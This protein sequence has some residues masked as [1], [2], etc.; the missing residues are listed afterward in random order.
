MKNQEIR[1]LS[2]DELKER[3]AAEK[4]GLQKLKFAHEISPVENPMKIRHSRRLIAK[5]ETE[6]RAKEITN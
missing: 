4:E 2:A 6:L 3:I 1:S 5:M